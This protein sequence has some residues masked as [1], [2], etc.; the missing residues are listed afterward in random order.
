MIKFHVIFQTSRKFVIE[1]GNQ[2]K[3][4]TKTPYIVWVNGKYWMNSNRVVETID[5]LEP[6]TEYEI[7]IRNKE[8]DS[9]PKRLRTDFEYVTLN[10]RD[11][12]A[13]GNGENDDTLAI[14]AAISC[15]P[16][17]SRILVPEGVYKVSSLF[18]KSHMEFRMED[19]AVLLGTT[20][21]EQYPIMRNRVAGIEMDWP[22]GILNVMDQEDVQIT[23]EGC[24]DGQGPYWWNKYWGEDQKGGMRAEYDPMGLR[25]CVDYDCRRVR[26]LVVMDSRRIEIAGIGSR[27]SGFWN[28]HI[29][30]SEDV[31]VDGV[32]IRDNEGPSTDGIDIDSCRHV[33][34]ENCR[35]ACN[36]DSIC[37]KSGRD[38]DGLRVNRICEDVLIQNCQVLT[39][40][41][42]TLGS[43]TSGGIRNVTIRNMKYHGTDCG[44][45]IKSAAT[46]GGVME[47][48]LVED[49]EMVNV[50]YPINM[51]LNWH[52]AYSYC[53]IPKGYEGEIPEH[54]KVLAQSVSRE[55]GVPQVKNLQIR[56]V[57]SWNE[58]GYEGCSRAFE[59]D[60]F[61][62]RPME[63]VVLEHVDIKAKEFGRIAG[64]KNWQW[65]DVNIS[66]EGRNQD[67][68]N[69]YDVR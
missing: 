9:E 14:Q 58:E 51:C 65:K 36:D 19:A 24:I 6:D 54:W 17:D 64:I 46:R 32:W 63:N 45:R 41:G 31:H 29:C 18:L 37:V 26:N 62:E 59:V 61:P 49:L 10:V 52:P 23:G 5:G 21:E 66:V 8:G 2:G 28:M 20:E 34:V 42:V 15:C 25:W 48:I 11:F 27:R 47:D 68:N 67:E 35:V 16:K 57:R 55:M 22:V 1:L 12:G 39:G 50:K 13:K 60:A 53:E 7:I 69:V 40:C 56:N 38:A 33:V 3:F 30:Y 43:E 4:T 44:F